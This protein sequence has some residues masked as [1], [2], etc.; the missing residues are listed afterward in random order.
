MQLQDGLWKMKTLQKLA[1]DVDGNYIK[2]ADGKIQVVPVAPGETYLYALVGG[3]EDGK[4][5]RDEATGKFAVN[6]DGTVMR[7]FETIPNA[8]WDKVK[9]TVGTKIDGTVFNDKQRDDI[10]S[11]EK[12]EVISGVKVTLLD[13]DGNQIA[14]TTTDENGYYYFYVNPNSSYTLSLERPESYDAT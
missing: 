7:S 8:K 14:E 4:F 12:D 5:I 10:Y 11:S 9:I 6:S 1:V 3:G 13:K 2:T